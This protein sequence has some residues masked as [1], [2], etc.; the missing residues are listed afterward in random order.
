[1]EIWV[2]R[3]PAVHDVW[4]VRPWNERV[5]ERIIQTISWLVDLREAK[6]I[7]NVGYETVSIRW[8]EVG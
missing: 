3:C 2:A 5:C 4:H 8:Y 7:V 1:M 6:D